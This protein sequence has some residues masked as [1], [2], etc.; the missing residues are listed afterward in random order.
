MGFVQCVI[1]RDQDTDTWREGHIEMKDEDQFYHPEKKNNLI[2]T[3]FLLFQPP[4]SRENRFCSLI[5]LVC[6]ILL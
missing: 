6:G 2:G 5:H 4:E 3:L 1:I